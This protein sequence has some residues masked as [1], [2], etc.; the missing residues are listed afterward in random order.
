MTT[1]SDQ[2]MLRTMNVPAKAFAY[3]DRRGAPV[4]M[5][6]AQ[7]DRASVS[8]FTATNVIRSSSRHLS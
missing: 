8:L 5:R 3:P 6:A 1:N 7:R 2:S 4:E